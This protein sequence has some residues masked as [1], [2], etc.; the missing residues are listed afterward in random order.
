MNEWQSKQPEENYTQQERVWE[1]LESHSL[2]QP[3]PVPAF[4]GET[5]NHLPDFERGMLLKG[6]GSLWLHTPKVLVNPAQRAGF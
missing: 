2:G 6:K 5:A 4:C 3:R 1:S